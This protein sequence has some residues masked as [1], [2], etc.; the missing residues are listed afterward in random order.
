MTTEVMSPSSRGELVPVPQAPAEAE[1]EATKRTKSPVFWWL[2]WSII[3]ALVV[4][5][6]HN[7]IPQT[8]DVLHPTKFL[9]AVAVI[10]TAI[11]AISILPPLLRPEG[12]LVKW[13]KTVLILI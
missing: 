13:A 10:S 2:F 5:A 6:F 4:A 12:G 3:A 8:F 11:F 1:N 7:P 9:I